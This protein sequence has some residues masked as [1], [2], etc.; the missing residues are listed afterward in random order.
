MNVRN[1]KCKVCKSEF[2]PFNSLQKVCSTKCA[3]ILSKELKSKKARVEKR[4]ALEA[5]KTH[6][7]WLKDLQKVFNSYIRK[8]DK[9]KGCISCGCSLIGRKFDAGH[10]RSV[11]SSP[12]LRFNENNVH[13]QCVPCNRNQHGNI[14]E[15]RKGLIK[16][17]GLDE[18][19]KIEYNHTTEKLSIPEIKEKI[20]EYKEKVRQLKK[21]SVL[22]A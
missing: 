5:L 17:I 15:Y 8:R 12:H 13:G 19:L 18:L 22:T 21:E 20:T 3:V 2:R 4:K 1:K 16:R 11:G 10:Y 14:V 9:N 6:K 7:D